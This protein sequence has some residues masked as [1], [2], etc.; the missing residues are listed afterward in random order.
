MIAVAIDVDAV[1]IDIVDAESGLYSPS[2]RS[3]GQ[4]K[5]ERE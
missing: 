3:D 1:E 2:L 5:G 4:D